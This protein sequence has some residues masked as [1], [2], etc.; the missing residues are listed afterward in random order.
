MWALSRC[1]GFSFHPIQSWWVQESQHRGSLPQCSMLHVMD[2]WEMQL[3]QLK[4][5]GPCKQ[6]GGCRKR[7]GKPS[8]WE[9]PSSAALPS[10]APVLPGERIARQSTGAARELAPC[11]PVLPMK[12]HQNFYNVLI[13]SSLLLLTFLGPSLTCLNSYIDETVSF[14]G[15]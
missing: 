12:P 11:C 2:E 1:F 9:P 10:I 3:L 8:A 5:S 4:D 15:F 13:W 7:E 14:P 6:S